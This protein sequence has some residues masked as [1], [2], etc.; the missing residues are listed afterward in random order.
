[1]NVF[2]GI[3]SNVTQ[4][5]SDAIYINLPVTYLTVGKNK[6]TKTPKQMQLL[7]V[8]TTVFELFIGCVF[9]Y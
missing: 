2:L 3:C 9:P 7:T 1:M 8:Q 5:A 6:K 4:L